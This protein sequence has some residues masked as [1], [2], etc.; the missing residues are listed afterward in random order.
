MEVIEPYYPKSGK[1]GR[2]PMG[3][4]R[5]YFVQQCYG[6]ADEAVE[7]S[8]YDSQALRKFMGIDLA[9]PAYPTPPP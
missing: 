3:L 4:E 9:A 8:V 2:P 1:R 5:M 7:A 6:L